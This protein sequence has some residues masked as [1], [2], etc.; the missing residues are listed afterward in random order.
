MW[1]CGHNSPAAQRKRYSFTRHKLKPGQ[2]FLRPEDSALQRLLWVTYLT[3][4]WSSLREA[5]GMPHEKPHLANRGIS[6][7]AVEGRKAGTNTHT[8]CPLG[9]CTAKSRLFPPFRQTSPES[10]VSKRTSPPARR[11]WRYRT[12]PRTG[13]GRGRG[14]AQGLEEAS[15]LGASQ[16]FIPSSPYCRRHPA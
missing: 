16:C 5:V 14:L 13:A 9:N 15:R 3:P 11:A 1:P 8:A 2:S 12:Q 7:T 10:S 4:G 6:G